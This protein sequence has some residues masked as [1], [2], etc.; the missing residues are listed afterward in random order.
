[1]SGFQQGDY[2]SFVSI[3]H[4]SD[5]ADDNDSSTNSIMPQVDKE[6]L[7]LW[8]KVKVFNPEMLVFQRKAPAFFDIGSQLSFISEELAN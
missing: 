2:C 1:M 4:I 6:V 7:L 3:R 5:K 8:K